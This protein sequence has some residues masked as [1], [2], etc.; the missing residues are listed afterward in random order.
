MVPPF[1]IIAGK[2]HRE[3][4]TNAVTADVASILKVTP[5]ERFTGKGWFRYDGI[6]SC[7][8]RGSLTSELLPLFI[9]LL[10]TN[11][12]NVVHEE[13]HVV[14]MLEGNSSRKGPSWLREANEL[15]LILVL[16]SANTTHFLQPCDRRVNKRI[17]KELRRTRDS[18]IEAGMISTN[19]VQFKLI[20]DISA[21]FSVSEQ[22]VRTSFTVRGR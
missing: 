6:I 1:F 8:D 7:R 10:N 5:F 14:L 20:Y 12:R 2:K 3:K 15:K 9:R 22:D 16:S 19:A 13:K 11:I 21:M 17:S 4:W 18:I